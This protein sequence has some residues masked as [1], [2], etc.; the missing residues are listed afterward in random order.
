MHSV[1]WLYLAPLPASN[2]THQLPTQLPP[3]NISSFVFFFFYNNSLSPI[4]AAHKWMSLV[5]PLGV[6]SNLTM[7]TPLKISI[8]PSAVTDCQ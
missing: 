6:I 3:N 5:H 2:S 7:A 4:R 8:F 1:L